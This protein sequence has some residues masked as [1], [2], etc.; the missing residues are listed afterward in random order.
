[1][2]YV[3]PN[4][5]F[6]GGS[7]ASAEGTR[8]PSAKVATVDSAPQE[9]PPAIASLDGTVTMPPI[10]LNH[11][12][13]KIQVASQSPSRVGTF[14][15]RDGDSETTVVHTKQHSSNKGTGSAVKSKK[16]DQNDET[17]FVY[18]NSP[19]TPEPQKLRDC[20]KTNT[21][22]STAGAK[23]DL[24]NSRARS[25]ASTTDSCVVNEKLSFEE[26]AIRDS[27]RA[28][29]SIEKETAARSKSTAYATGQHK[30]STE[31]S[32][33]PESIQSDGSNRNMALLE[34]SKSKGAS[35]EETITNAKYNGPEPSQANVEKIETNEG[36]NDEGTPGSMHPLSRDSTIMPCTPLAL[37]EVKEE[38]DVDGELKVPQEGKAGA[39][40][41]GWK[42]GRKVR[43]S[44]FDGNS[45]P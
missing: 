45:E 2:R 14:G 1:M 35:S 18:Y 24:G 28:M 19:T 27:I 41:V 36:H 26:P 23:L 12:T 13:Q 20:V 3:A 40:T 21:S 4:K 32:D 44:F 5:I 15:Q 37:E 34:L 9:N 33:I 42:Y 30:Q 10:E 39:M 22:E 8:K 38:I 29:L 25:S 7:A 43:P 11:L 16:V 17:V 31:L 6:G